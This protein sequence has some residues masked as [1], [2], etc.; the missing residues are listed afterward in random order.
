MMRQSL[1]R[2]LGSGSRMMDSRDGD[3]RWRLEMETGDGDQ[4]WRPEME[5]RN[6]D[7]NRRW[8]PEMEMEMEMEIKTEGVWR[9][10]KQTETKGVEKDMSEEE[11]NGM[12]GKIIKFQKDES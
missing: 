4:K 12:T 5:T 9:V 2:V 3:R 11:E 7:K 6:G 1:V 10:D 8:R